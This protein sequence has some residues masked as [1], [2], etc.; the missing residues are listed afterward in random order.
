MPQGLLD[1]FYEVSGPRVEA[2]KFGDCLS[3]GS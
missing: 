3:R 2:E 1:G